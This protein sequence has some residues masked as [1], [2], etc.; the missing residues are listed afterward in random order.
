M[1]GFLVGAV[2]AGASAIASGQFTP[3]VNINSRYIVE[4]IQLSGAAFTLSRSLNEEI[5]NLVGGN[6]DPN[7]LDGLTVR[8]K[9]ELHAK[10]VSYRISRGDRPQQVKVNFEITRRS[11]ELDVN[12]PKFLYSTALGW[13]GAV[14]G[15][16]RTGSHSL[17]ANLLSDD[18]ELVERKTGIALRY[19]NKKLG[20]D[21]L[22]MSFLFEGYHEG[23]SHSTQATEQARLAGAPRGAERPP[24]GLSDPP[25]FSTH[26]YN[27]S[28]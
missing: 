26:V 22:G 9:K 8:I 18:D 4:S 12:V 2:L 16:A 20:S 1:K 27:R 25:K 7:T 24:R 23:W 15:V 10:T 28:R 5:Q 3:I 21:R 17:T 19:E 6:F 14:E 11:V 13:S